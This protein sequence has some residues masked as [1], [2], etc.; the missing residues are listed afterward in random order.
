M[1]EFPTVY[2]ARE[3]GRVHEVK[4]EP[5]SSMTKQEFKDECDINVIMSKYVTLGVL[6]VGVK[7]AEY[8]DFAQAPDFHEAMNI[9]A[10]AREQF[11]AL[12]SK[13]RDRFKN[14]PEEFLKFVHDEKNVDECKEL[15]LLSAE[16]VAKVDAKLAAAKAQA[17]KDAAELAAVRAGSV[18]T[19]PKKVP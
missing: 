19:Q 9:L 16:G 8:G 10:V 18:A 17:D 11:A 1:M 14:D 5:G 4:C 6:P 7:T 3:R 13:V 15:G 12:P 2:T